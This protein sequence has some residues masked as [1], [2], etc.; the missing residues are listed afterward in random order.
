MPSDRDH[1]APPSTDPADWRPQALGNRPNSVVDPIVEPRW[2]GVRTLIRVESGVIAIVDETGV[3]C[4]AEFAELAAV[5]V[6]QTRADR[7]VLD[8]YLTVEPTQESRGVALTGIEAPTTGQVMAQ[9]IV[10]NRAIREQEPKTKIDPDRPIA[11]VAVDLLAIDGTT[12]LDVPLLER[13]RILDGV[14]SQNEL[15]RVTPFVRPP[16]GPYVET[17]RALGFRE[18]VFKASNSRYV[19]GG[20]TNEWSAAPLVI[21]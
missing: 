3:D 15:V 18:L 2:G 10:G 4:T 17:W 1:P 20:Q 12:L 9:M 8:G 13:K 21:R 14:V 5:I 19:P 6:A 16:I 7:A 11:F